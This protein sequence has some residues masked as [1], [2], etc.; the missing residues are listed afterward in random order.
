MLYCLH[1]K[2]RFIAARLLYVERKACLR[3]EDDGNFSSIQ[4][5]DISVVCVVGANVITFNIRPLS[6][7]QQRFSDR[8]ALPVL[9]LILS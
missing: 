9:T 7:T 4:E 5:P 2:L 8:L 3:I 1:V 6:A